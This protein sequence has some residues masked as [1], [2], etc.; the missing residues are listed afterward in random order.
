MLVKSVLLLFISTSLC[1]PFI[2]GVCFGIFGLMVL[3]QQYKRI[4]PTLLPTLRPVQRNLG[5]SSLIPNSDKPD[6]TTGE[7]AHFQTPNPA[8]KSW[9]SR[10]SLQEVIKLSK[11]I[12]END[13]FRKVHLDSDEN[14]KTFVLQSSKS[15]IPNY[16]FLNI[17]RNDRVITIGLRGSRSLDDW[18][19][20]SLRASKTAWDDIL[21]SQVETECLIHKGL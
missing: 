12:L 20:Y 9:L 16:G 8:E 5:V 21:G 17:N 6:K 1:A 13:F 4:S 10:I 15:N 19:S 2:P 3:K 7:N 14:S 11:S 18:R